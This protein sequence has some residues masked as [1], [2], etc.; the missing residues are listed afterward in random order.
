MAFSLGLC[1]STCVNKSDRPE[2]SVKP[3]TSNRGFVE[4]PMISSCFVFGVVQVVKNAR[5]RIGKHRQGPVERDAMFREI[6]LR[7]G[8]IPFEL[9]VHEN[10][11]SQRFGLSRGDAKRR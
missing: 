10:A 8:V 2:R 9:K 1:R 7:L 6:G 3:T 11:P 5:Q 4:K